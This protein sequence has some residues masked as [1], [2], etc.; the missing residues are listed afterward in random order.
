MAMYVNDRTKNRK[1]HILRN[2]GFN[3]ISFVVLH[4]IVVKMIAVTLAMIK[5]MNPISK[6]HINFND[7]GIEKNNRMVVISAALLNMSFFFLENFF[8]NR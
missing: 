6:D 1:R 7:A 8:K 4:S 2:N 3:S 5:T